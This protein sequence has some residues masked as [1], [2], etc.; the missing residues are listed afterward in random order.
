M[1]EQNTRYYVT[2]LATVETI[3]NMENLTRTVSPVQHSLAPCQ[4]LMTRSA[5]AGTAASN[6][7]CE[8]GVEGSCNV[9]FAL[10]PDSERYIVIEVNPR[11][12]RSSAL[13]SKA[14]GYPIAKVASKIAAGYTLDE[15]Q[16]AVTQKTTACFEPSLDYVVLKIPRWPFDKFVSADRTLGT[17]MKATGEVM[18]IERNMEAALLKAVRSLESADSPRDA[19]IEGA[20]R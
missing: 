7:V 8:L 3:C 6:I 14:T 10:D 13:A 16:N 19:R 11:V 18:A 2:L 9:Q 15:I 12:S 20:F 1:K 4:R 17:Q 5:D